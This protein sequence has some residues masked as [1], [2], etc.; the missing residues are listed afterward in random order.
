MQECR[1]TE[2]TCLFIHYPISDKRTIICVSKLVILFI[3]TLANKGKKQCLPN[4]R[5]AKVK[6]RIGSEVQSNFTYTCI[7]VQTLSFTS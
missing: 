2:H 7:H 4:D 1:R 6:L 5:I 3:I